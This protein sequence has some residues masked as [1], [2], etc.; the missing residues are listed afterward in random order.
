[1]HFNESVEVTLC[2]TLFNDQE[3]TLKKTPELTARVKAVACAE[4][5]YQKDHKH[6][7]MAFPL[8]V[9]RAS[10]TIDPTEVR[11]FCDEFS[12]RMKIKLPNA[13][14]HLR[15]DTKI[16][17]SDCSSATQAQH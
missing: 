9:T 10:C 13:R 14:A 8:V 3:E 2:S 11:R 4:K 6:K 5:K 16:L 17:F 15:T 1:M 7:R 12:Y